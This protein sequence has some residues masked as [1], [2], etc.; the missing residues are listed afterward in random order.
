MLH[1]SMLGSVPR[2]SQF[3]GLL[4]ALLLAGSTFLA[5]TTTGVAHASAGSAV[6]YANSHWNWSYYDPQNH[7]LVPKGAGQNNFQCAEFVAR[8]LSTLGIIYGPHGNLGPNSPQSAY[9]SD[10]IGSKTWDLLWVGYAP[11]YNGLKQY[12]LANGLVKD[13]G[14]HIAQASPGD[15]VI[16]PGSDGRGHTALLVKI[17]GKNSL[18][19]QHN[20]AY[21]DINYQEYA[22]IDILHV[23]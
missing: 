21:K 12:L 22:S 2:R 23:W 4:L 8:A 1:F 10:K 17:N 18:V 20:V 14:N 3:L 7:T 13:I 16:Y 9:L 11:P 6:T 19:D 15:I 5:F